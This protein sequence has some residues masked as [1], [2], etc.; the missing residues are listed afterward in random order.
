[1]DGVDLLGHIDRLKES[2][3][4]AAAKGGRLEECASLRDIGADVNW[5]SPEGDTC[6]LAAARNGHIE[7]VNYLLAQGSSIDYAMPATGNTALHLAAQ[8]G[9]TELA[10]A[11]T[12]VIRRRRVPTEDPPVL[13]RATFERTTH[14][15]R[16]HNLPN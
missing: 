5:V 9:Q 3:L 10:L 13:P 4:W 16:T 12:V 6:L 1:M 14:R 2:F 11:L 15:E 8:R 7:V